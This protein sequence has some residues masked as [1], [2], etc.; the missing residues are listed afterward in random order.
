MNYL[1]I[2]DRVWVDANKAAL[3]LIAV[4]IA[5]EEGALVITQVEHADY[6]SVT[7][8]DAGE[9]MVLHIVEQTDGCNIDLRDF[10]L[11]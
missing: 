3:L 2:G 9:L 8:I 4:E 6:V 5:S 10:Q 7:R 1:I 11:A